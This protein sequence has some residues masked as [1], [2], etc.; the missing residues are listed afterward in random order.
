MQDVTPLN[1]AIVH[2]I[3]VVVKDG[4]YWIAECHTG[5]QLALTPKQLLSP[6]AVQLAFVKDLGKYVSIGIK[7]EWERR[8]KILIEAPTIRHYPKMCLADFSMAR[9]KKH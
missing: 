7:A 4:F 6:K 3:R 1:R 5:G 2:L 8:L 9:A